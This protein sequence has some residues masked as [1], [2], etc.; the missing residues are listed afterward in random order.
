MYKYRLKEVAP[1][2]PTTAE[3]YQ[4]QRIKAFDGIEAKLDTLKKYIAKAKLHTIRYYRENPD[5]YDV[6]YGTDLADSYIKDLFTLF[7]DEK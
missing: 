7:K 6:L 3:S 2:A 4:E 1:V 5:S